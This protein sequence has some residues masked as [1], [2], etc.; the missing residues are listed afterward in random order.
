MFW[1]GE[2]SEVVDILFQI[3]WLKAIISLLKIRSF[4]DH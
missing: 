4:R 1:A 2:T 3:F